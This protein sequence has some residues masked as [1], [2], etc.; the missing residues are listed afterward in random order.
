V[1]TSHSPLDT[2]RAFIAAIERKDFDEAT[3]LLAD[4]CEY[5]NVPMTKVF[6]PEAIRAALEPF[7]GAC[8]GIE[9]LVSRESATGPVVF[10]ERVDRFQMPHGWVTI[11]VT[12]V[13]EVVDGRITLWR[14]YFDLETFRTQMTPNS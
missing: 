10:N 11:P 7:V 6:G 5:D 14:D 8:D 13:W 12:G 4:G 2:V 3:S 9:W 1:T